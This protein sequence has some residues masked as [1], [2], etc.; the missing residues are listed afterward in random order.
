MCRE[1]ILKEINMQYDSFFD[2]EDNKTLMAICTRRL[3]RNIG[4]GGIIWGIIN[5]LL[6][7]AAI[8]VTAL[9]AG[10]LILGVLMLITGAY[11]LKK[12]SFEVLQAETLVC[13]LL[14]FWNV[15]IAI[16]NTM[17]GST[18]EPRGL[19]FP[20]IIAV[21]MFKYYRRLGYLRGRIESVE[22]EQINQTRQMCKTLLKIK[23]KNEPSVIKTT[24]GRCRVKFMDK[25]GLFIQRDMMRAFIATKEE[26]FLA[27]QKPYTNNFKL[28]FNHPAGQLIYIFDKKNS[29]KLKTWLTSD[30]VPEP[31]AT[32]NKSQTSQPEAV[33]SVK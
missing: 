30:N 28:V 26:I 11:A 3:I 7:I 5:L 20:G 19:I 2:T 18:F 10:I 22:P 1:T 8:Q 14:F 23:L 13:A 27:I 12:P 17:A 21:V 31:A 15:G 33:L 24:N 29:E 16:L 25:T 32:E 6:G 9:N 4:I